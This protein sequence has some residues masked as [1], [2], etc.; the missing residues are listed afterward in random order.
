MDC[1]DFG[2]EE[3][4]VK[5]AWFIV[6]RAQAMLKNSKLFSVVITTLRS[7]SFTQPRIAQVLKKS[8]SE[9]GS[10]TSLHRQPTHLLIHSPICASAC[11]PAASRAFHIGHA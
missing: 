7:R 9:N 6:L 11:R 2:L 10:E 8:R 4:H 1:K 3:L 5:T